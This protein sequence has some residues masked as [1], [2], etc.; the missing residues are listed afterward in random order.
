MNNPDPDR[1]FPV[2]VIGVDALKSRFDLQQSE[3]AKLKEHTKS[4]REVLD[5]VDS[6]NM[7]IGARFQSLQMKQ[8]HIYQKMLALLRKVEVLRC[9]GL[10]ME[11]AEMRYDELYESIACSS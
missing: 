7:Q 2:R 1:Y 9:K 8:I 4:V 10:P 3:S 11:Q 6:S 5:A